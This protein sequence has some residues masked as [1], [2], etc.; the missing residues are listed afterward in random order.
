MANKTII[1]NLSGVHEELLIAI[2]DNAKKRKV[3]ISHYVR[4]LLYNCIN[5]SEYVNKAPAIVDVGRTERALADG[6]WEYSH[7]KKEVAS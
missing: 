1:I 5:E 7:E 6:L 3:S 4:T 2:R